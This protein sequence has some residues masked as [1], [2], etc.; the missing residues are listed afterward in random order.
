MCISTI[1]STLP[2]KATFILE[3]KL[4]ELNALSGSH[5]TNGS[6]DKVVFK[7]ILNETTKILYRLENYLYYMDIG[8]YPYK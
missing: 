8:I 7:A 4:S 5:K 2:I 1:D 3:S 6:P